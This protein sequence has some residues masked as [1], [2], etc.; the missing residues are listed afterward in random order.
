M[1]LAALSTLISGSDKD[2]EHRP[3]PGSAAALGPADIGRR[4]AGAPAAA[5]ASAA[6]K[7]ARDPKDIWDTDEVPTADDLAE[8]DAHA[9]DGRSRPEYEF[10]LRQDVTSEDMYLGM[11]DKDPSSA[12]CDF[13][14]VRVKLPGE[15][16]S[17]VDLDV[18]P[19]AIV[20]RS[21]KFRLATYLPH[22][23]KHEDGKARW[24]A[25]KSMLEVVLRVDRK[26]L[27]ELE[28]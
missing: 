24:I 14:V 3:A 19:Q 4:P 6:P 5:A 10:L 26:E 15:A 17:E 2:A 23:V 8:E 9:E 11:G 18:K 27:W 25:S 28:D 7:K 20:V 16:V 13:L 22:R 12:K 21:P 1:D